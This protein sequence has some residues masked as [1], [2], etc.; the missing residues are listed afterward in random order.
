MGM[1][2]PMGL[3]QPASNVTALR[4][5][6]ASQVQERV[7]IRDPMP[8]MDEPVVEQAPRPL[9]QVPRTKQPSSLFS[10][11]APAAMPAQPATEPVTRSLFQQA[12]GLFRRRAVQTPVVPEPVTRRREPVAEPVQQAAHELQVDAD[13]AADRRA[14][15]ADDS[16]IEIP[17]FLRRQLSSS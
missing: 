6:A 8:L 5:Q 11:A 10:H 17:A 14:G 2:S 12:T 3:H 9:P 15:V 4:Q 7:V 1:V 16:G 13:R